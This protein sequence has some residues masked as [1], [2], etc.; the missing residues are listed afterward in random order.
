MSKT[1]SLDHAKHNDRQRVDMVANR[2]FELA[3]LAERVPFASVGRAIAG[4]NVRSS[5]CAGSSAS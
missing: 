5:V 2:E 1:K 4:N 3:E